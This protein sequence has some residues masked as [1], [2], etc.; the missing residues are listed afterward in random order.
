MCVLL[1]RGKPKHNAGPW[2][3][4]VLVAYAGGAGLVV[5]KQLTGDK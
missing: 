1:R 5:A 3:G 2:V 4:P